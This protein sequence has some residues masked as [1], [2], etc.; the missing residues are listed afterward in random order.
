M[1]N[2]IEKVIDETI[3]GFIDTV[4]SNYNI[5]KEEL[6]RIWT[7]GYQQSK[8]AA[9]EEVREQPKPVVREEVREQQSKSAA[10]EE[11]RQSKSAAREEVRE[12][13]KP[14]V[15]EEVR[16]VPKPV[17]REEVREVPKPVVREEVREQAESS[18]NANKK[19]RKV[20]S[21]DN[22]E[23]KYILLRGSKK[24]QACGC[25]IRKKGN[26]FCSKHN[27]EDGDEKKVKQTKLSAPLDLSNKIVLRR[28]KT[29]DKLWHEDSGMVFE[30]VSNRVVIGRC[31]GDQ[32]RPLTATDVAV[33]KELSFAIAVPLE[34]PKP[35]AMK[36]ED[37][38]G[39]TIKY[40][41][42]LLNSLQESPKKKSGRDDS[43]S[44][45]DSSDSDSESSDSDLEEEE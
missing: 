8:S 6:Q 34:V 1:N 20:V 14:V 24:G 41:E 7:N 28:N 5:S 30:S 33:C 25:A 38:D 23:C 17:V 10:R 37:K 19:K 3:N 45:S 32:I 44:D 4:S 31:E 15:R 21:L 39:D 43:D 42:K 11:V 12:V 2:I 13:P 29:I 9:R 18:E 35:E 22:A 16:E 40:V 26:D 27:S 36:H